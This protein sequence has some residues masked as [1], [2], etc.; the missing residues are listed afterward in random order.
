M[1]LAKVRAD[2]HQ[3]ALDVLRS[4]AAEAAAA[5]DDL[6]IMAST[7]GPHIVA[8]ACSPVCIKHGNVL[9]LVQRSLALY[10]DALSPLTNAARAAPRCEPSEA[11]SGA[12]GWVVPGKPRGKT[13]TNLRVCRWRCCARQMTAARLWTSAP[14]R[15]E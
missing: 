15:P 6:R 2:E 13:R 8:G 14:A 1:R 10:L 7:I 3:A 5:S 11:S 12:L 9:N 4:E